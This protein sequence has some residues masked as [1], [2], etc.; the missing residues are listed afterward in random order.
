MSESPVYLVN[1]YVLVE[2][3]E[4][5]RKLCGRIIGI[6]EKGQETIYRVRV[7]VAEL[8]EQRRFDDI[9][10]VPGRLVSPLEI[11]VVSKKRAGEE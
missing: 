6:S 2:Y 11:A 3:P 7:F 5:K 9:V 8:S 4:L 10:E 1:D